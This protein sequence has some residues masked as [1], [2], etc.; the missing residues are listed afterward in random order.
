VPEVL[1]T[2][3]IDETILVESEDAGKMARSL[4]AREGILSGISSGAAA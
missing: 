4:S 1:N 2:D 3:V